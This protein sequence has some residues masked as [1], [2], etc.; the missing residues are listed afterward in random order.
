MKIDFL[1]AKSKIT[2]SHNISPIE[3]K[4]GEHYTLSSLN[5][6]RRKFSE[7]TSTPYVL[8]YKGS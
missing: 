8:P 5:K 1:T 7:Y 2:N 3:V 6:F 4:S